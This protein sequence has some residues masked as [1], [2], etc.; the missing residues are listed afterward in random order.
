[1]SIKNTLIHII[2][3]SLDTISSLNKEDYQNIII[4]IPSKKENGDYSTNI[5]LTLTK[6]LHKSPI[7]IAEDIVKKPALSEED[8]QKE[9]DFYMAE[10]LSKILL[11][12]GLLTEEE[13]IRLSVKNRETFSPYLC[14]IMAKSA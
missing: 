13:C 10:K 3:C 12:N 6:K 11:D 14:S 1:M 4:E 7:A 2:K 9:Y 5:A 8:L